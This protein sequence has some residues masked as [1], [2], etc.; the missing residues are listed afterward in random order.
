VKTIEQ[1]NREG[2]RQPVRPSSHAPAAA[3]HC[4]SQ[5]DTS[6][7]IAPYHP[8]WPARFRVEAEVLRVALSP[9]SPVVEHV[10]STAVP[11]LSAMP[12]IDIAVGVSDPALVDDHAARLENFGYR[13]MT[14]PEYQVADR[15][16]LLRIVRGVR[17]HH[18]HVVTAFG[19]AWHLLL[20]FRDM[21]RLDRDLAI[22][23]DALKRELARQ[24][25]GRPLL[26]AAGK[27]D[28][29]RSMLGRTAFKPADR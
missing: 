9:L 27:A 25:Q 26:Y 19:D 3:D 4:G 28:F 8:S 13:L 6:I 18:V 22:T 11:A 12:V 23:Y 15:R 29:I 17:T 1:A 2:R 10:G 21:L 24:N 7:E 20:M 5:P 14:T 16:V